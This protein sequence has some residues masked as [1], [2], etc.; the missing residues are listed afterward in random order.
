MLHFCALRSLVEEV[1]EV[2]R[3]CHAWWSVSYFEL[4]GFEN[5]SWLVALVG[6]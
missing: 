6:I 1:D 4:T 3:D 2:S 5:R